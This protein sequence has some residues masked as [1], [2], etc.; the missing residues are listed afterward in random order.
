MIYIQLTQLPRFQ[1]RLPKTIYLRNKYEV[2]LAEIAYP[3]KLSTFN[4]IEDYAFKCSD[5]QG[6]VHTLKI[7][8]GYYKTMTHLVSKLNDSIVEHDNCAGDAVFIYDTISGK[9]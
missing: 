8:H 3:H 5:I 4:Y 2:A 1:I 6:N 7:P 9:A